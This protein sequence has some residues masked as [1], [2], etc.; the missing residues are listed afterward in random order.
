MTFLVPPERSAAIVASSV[1]GLGIEHG[2]T[3]CHGSAVGGVL[4]VGVRQTA[5]LHRRADL[6]ATLILDHGEE[7]GIT[8]AAEL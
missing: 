3:G 5:N 4:G 6:A 8:C 7:F 1:V 2:Y